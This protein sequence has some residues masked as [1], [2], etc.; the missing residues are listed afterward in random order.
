MPSPT[1]PS[2]TS[3]IPGAPLQA[4]QIVQARLPEVEISEH[5]LV[6][7]SRQRHGQV[8]NRRRLPL[9]VGG[10]RN[11]NRPCADLLVGDLEAGP[12]HPIRVGLWAQWIRHQSQVVLLQIAAGRWNSPQHAQ[13]EQVAYLVDGA[14]AIV[15]R[16]DQEDE[17][18][19]EQD[20]EDEAQHPVAHGRRR[21][22]RG[23]F[24]LLDHQGRRS[25]QHEERRQ[26][27]LLLDQV[28]VERR[29]L[30]PCTLE[31]RDAVLDPLVRLRD[32]P[33]IEI[34]PVTRER[35]GIGSRQAFCDSRIRMLDGQ[36][37]EIAP[38]VRGR[39]RGL[40]HLQRGEPA[41]GYL[42]ERSSRHLGHPGQLRL[43]LGLSRWVDV[44]RLD[45]A[46]AAGEIL[47]LQEDLSRGL[48]HLR[49]AHRQEHGDD[50]DEHDDG[51]QDP[52]PPSNDANVLRQRRRGCQA[53]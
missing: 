35:L 53:T 24:R 34:C 27:P 48:V 37:E 28:L 36:R 33:G 6:I 39:G 16:L 44:R 45:S 49:A 42:G 4:E 17:P 22:L 9:S 15:E 46:E 23:A 1:S 12:Q 43:G 40:Q 52:L 26:L 50:G 25:V 14:H 7:R 29:A 41:F 30:E 32:L 51:E 10:A 2:S 18:Q 5:D 13:A 47:P 38:G 31:L 21:D 19:P 3:T 20:P 11:E 8:R